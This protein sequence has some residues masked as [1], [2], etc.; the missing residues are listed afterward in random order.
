MLESHSHNIESQRFSPEAVVRR[1]DSWAASYDED[2]F[3]TSYGRYVHAQEEKLLRMWLAPAARGRVLSLACGTGRFMDFATH[4]ID[5]SNEMAE[6]ARKK[7]PTKTIRVGRA[8]ELPE[9]GLQFDAIFC[10]HLFMHLTP[11][12]MTQILAGCARCV[13]AG[14]RLIF[15]IPSARR[16]SLTGFRPS[17]WHAGNART[18]PQVVEVLGARWK[19]RA[20]R[21]ILFF[22]IHRVPV[23]LR[24]LLRP[25]DDACSATPLKHWAS[26]L[27]Y[28]AERLP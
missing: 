22:P 27:M 24:R 2:R 7:H 18:H 23:K 15:D 13:P 21:G 8:E 10:L 26:Y 16:R 25:W 3:G 6:L 11:S 19:L 20:W 4:G 9:Q 17:G 1:F 14:G 12:L 5:A 28:C